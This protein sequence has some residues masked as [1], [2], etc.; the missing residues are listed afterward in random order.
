MGWSDPRLPSYEGLSVTLTG[1]G[2][3]VTPAFEG[4]IFD[5]ALPMPD[6]IEPTTE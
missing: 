3:R 2:D 6:P 4:F 5:S 1:S